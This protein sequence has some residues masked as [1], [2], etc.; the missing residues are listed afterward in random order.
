MQQRLEAASGC[1]VDTHSCIEGCKVREA[2][3][4]EAGVSAMRDLQGYLDAL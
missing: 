4:T 3:L 1:V 2:S